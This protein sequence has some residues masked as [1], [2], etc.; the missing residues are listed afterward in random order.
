MEGSTKIKNQ[1]VQLPNIVLTDRKNY[2]YITK[3]IEGVTLNKLMVFHMNKKD[4]LVSIHERL[5][6][7]MND[8]YASNLEETQ[9][10]NPKNIIWK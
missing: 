1:N 8:Y 2:I 3:R 10:N 6:N 5:F 7:W 4:T 9:Y